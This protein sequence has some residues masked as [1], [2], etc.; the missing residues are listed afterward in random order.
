MCVHWFEY[1]VTEL[2]NMKSFPK[3]DP[4]IWVAAPI[5]HSRC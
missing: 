1:R 3:R 4:Y 5:G 2:I